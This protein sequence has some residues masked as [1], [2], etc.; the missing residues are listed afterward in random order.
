MSLA[1]ALAPPPVVRS[2]GPRD[3]ARLVALSRP[4]VRTGALRERPVSLYAARA[5][6]FLVVRGPGGGFDGCVGLRVYPAAADGAEGSAGVLYNFCVAAG[7]QGGGLGGALLRSVLDRARSRSLTALFT[8]TTGDGRLFGR[9]G[10]ISAEPDRAP[11]AWVRELDPR[12]GARILRRA[13]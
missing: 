12:R 1:P 2:A 13:L 7:R 9:Y 6:D 11:R 5:A 10:F 4:F 8:A 3:A